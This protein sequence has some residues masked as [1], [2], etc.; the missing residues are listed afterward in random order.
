MSSSFSSSSSSLEKFSNRVFNPTI[1]HK[2]K[3]HHLQRVWSWCFQ[4]ANSQEIQQFAI[5]DVETFW[6]YYN[7]CPAPSK[8]V[9]GS[10]VCFFEESFNTSFE[11]ETGSASVLFLRN[12]IPIRAEDKKESRD[13]EFK[14]ADTQWLEIL[15]ALIGEQ[16][17]DYN[18]WVKGCRLKV[19]RYGMYIEILMDLFI[20]PITRLSTSKK[21]DICEEETETEEGIHI[22]REIFQTIIEC[23]QASSLTLTPCCCTSPVPE[24]A[25]FSSS[26]KSSI[27]D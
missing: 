2:D 19:R 3:V 6:S 15:M 21:E 5:S 18:S 17:G 16:F 9:T 25:G 20:Q 8:I 22:I 7:N 13:F 14:K 4:L 27:F 11:E 1:S 24:S 12:K 26:N 10:S 23:Y